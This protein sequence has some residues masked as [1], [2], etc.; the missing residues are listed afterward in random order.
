MSDAEGITFEIPGDAVP[1]ARAG[2]NGKR[3]FTPAKQANYMSVVKL[4]AAQAMA[5]RKPFDGAIR[6]VIEAEYLPPASWSKKK[7]DAAEWK[8]SKPDADN[9]YK[10][11]A[12]SLNGVAF[13][14][15]A[16]VADVRISKTYASVSR[17]VVIVEPLT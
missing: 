9:L 14:D 7:Q 17:L 16:Q 4:F 15:D 8:T 13:V 1:F 3:R 2:A 6:V 11:V 5:G 12:D 10:L